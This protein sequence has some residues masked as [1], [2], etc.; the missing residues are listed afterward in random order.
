MYDS[1]KSFYD[2]VCAF[3]CA[4][5]LFILLFTGNIRAQDNPQ[6]VPAIKSLLD[7]LNSCGID[8]V[9]IFTEGSQG[10]Y[11]VGD[12]PCKSEND[13]Y[14]IYIKQ[15]KCFIKRYDGCSM[16]RSI[17]FNHI[18]IFDFYFKNKKILSG[19]DTYYNKFIKS[20]KKNKIVFFPPVAVHFFFKSIF[21]LTQKDNIYLIVRDT[22]YDKDGN[23]LYIKSNWMRK[24]KEWTDLISNRLSAMDSNKFIKD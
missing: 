19:K 21:F 6:S 16:Y 8:T 1:H 15:S 18:D 5:I 3:P 24:Q 9:L 12:D 2:K 11:V 22:E 4:F 7:S 10:C 17:E 23:P 13:Y 14:L 20:S